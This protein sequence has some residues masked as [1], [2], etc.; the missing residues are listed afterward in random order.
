MSIGDS[1]TQISF[2][3]SDKSKTFEY[4]ECQFRAPLIGVATFEFGRGISCNS[5]VFASCLLCDWNLARQEAKVRNTTA[6]TACI[7][8]P[9][10]LPHILQLRCVLSQK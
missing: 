7:H 1:K 4:D 8:G 10:H 5:G 3:S 6:K 2:S 9:S